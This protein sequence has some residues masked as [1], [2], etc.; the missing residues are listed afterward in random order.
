MQRMWKI[1]QSILRD[2]NR[3]SLEDVMFLSLVSHMISE[4]KR[5]ELNAQL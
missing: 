5:Q 2:D 4:D 1:V 3:R